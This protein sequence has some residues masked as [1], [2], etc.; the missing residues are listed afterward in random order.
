MG[1]PDGAPA[2]LSF[3][4]GELM[5]SDDDQRARG[6]E[7]LARLRA[8]APMIDAAV[9][10]IEALRELPASLLSALFDADLFRIVLPRA[11][12]GGEIRPLEL[13]RFME[14]AGRHD[15]SVAKLYGMLTDRCLQSHPCGQSVLNRTTSKQPPSARADTSFFTMRLEPLERFRSRFGERAAH[16]LRR[17]VN[18]VSQERPTH[19]MFVIRF[20]EHR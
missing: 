14:T 16:V 2:A 6:E 8:L 13:S 12:G 7:R 17:I 11:Y 5:T 18:V 1:P 9:E 4:A 10:E 20:D 3:S 19:V 15:A